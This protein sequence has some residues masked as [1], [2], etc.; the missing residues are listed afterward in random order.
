MVGLVADEVAGGGLE[1]DVDVAGLWGGGGAAEQ[2]DVGGGGRAVGIIKYS[3]IGLHFGGPTE[4]GA[5]HKF[6]RGLNRFSTQ[7]Q[8]GNQVLFHSLEV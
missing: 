2:V 5:A 6:L 8:C 3:A 4:V 7:K 1:E